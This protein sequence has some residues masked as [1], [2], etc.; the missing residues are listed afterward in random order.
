[1]NSCCPYLYVH[2]M[3]EWNKVTVIDLGLGNLIW[4]KA[5]TYFLAI[6]KVVPS[7]IRSFNVRLW[8]KWARWISEERTLHPPFR[9]LLSHPRAATSKKR[10]LEEEPQ[11]RLSEHL[12]KERKPSTTT[13]GLD[14]CGAHS[15]I[16]IIK[17][18][19][20]KWGLATGTPCRPIYHPC[21]IAVVVRLLYVS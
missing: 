3:V 9:R 4:V 21:Y 13:E 20:T 16:M 1:M 18:I 19:E 5:L 10:L 11:M 8:S 14:V 12:K 7:Y 2:N 17:A 15:T 6:P